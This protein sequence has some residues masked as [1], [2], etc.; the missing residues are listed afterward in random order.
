MS[1]S[2]R[3]RDYI[4]ILDGNPLTGDWRY[5]STFDGIPEHKEEDQ[6][7]VDLCNRWLERQNDDRLKIEIVFDKTDIKLKLTN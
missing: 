4:F 1:K 6:D 7:L 2:K 3:G 5:N